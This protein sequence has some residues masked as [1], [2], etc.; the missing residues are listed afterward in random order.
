MRLTFHDHGIGIP[1]D[2]TARVCDPFFSTKPPGEGTGLGLSISHTIIKDHGGRLRIESR[3]GDYTKV[4]MELPAME[5]RAMSGKGSILIIDDEKSIRVT[6]SE[7]LADEGY[8]VTA[9]DSFNTAARA[10]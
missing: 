7:F 6:L 2:I 9:A 5:E 1:A 8:D 10:A 4:I 3:E